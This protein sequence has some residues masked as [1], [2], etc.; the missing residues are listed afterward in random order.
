MT[1]VRVLT[2]NVVFILNQ[3]Q[4]AV[5][6][7]ITSKMASDMLQYIVVFRMCIVE[8]DSALT[9]FALEKVMGIWKLEISL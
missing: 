8:I 4:E 7:Y 1:L 6:T 2:N 9:N 5:M 3:F